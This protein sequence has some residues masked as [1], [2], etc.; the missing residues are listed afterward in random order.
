[1][2]LRLAVSEADLLPSDRTVELSFPNYDKLPGEIREP[3]ESVGFHLARARWE[4]LLHLPPAINVFGDSSLYIVDAPGHLQGHINLLARTG[5]KKWIYLA[6]DICHDRRL[7]TRE[8]AIAEWKSDHG[9]T[10]CIHTDRS[11]AEQTLA[12][13]RDLEVQY[14]DEVEVILAHDDE[15]YEKAENKAKFWPGKM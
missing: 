7:L 13:V 8:L 15:W 1:M 14:G 5:P 10:C 4:P 6:G 2:A 9:V 3:V 11:K 12:A